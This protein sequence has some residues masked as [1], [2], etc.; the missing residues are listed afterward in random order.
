MSRSWTEAG[1]TRNAWTRP[2]VSVTDALTP[3]D[4]LVRVLPTR[5]RVRPGPDAPS[6]EDAGRGAPVAAAGETD[7]SVEHRERAV[8]HAR[9]AADGL[10]QRQ[11]AGSSAQAAPAR[12][13]HHNARSTVRIDHSRGRPI[14]AGGR[15]SMVAS[16]QT[17]AFARTTSS[18]AGA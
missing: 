15:A 14:R 4:L 10:S 13:S 7:A 3:V 2:S 6:I 9:A 16:R 11:P 8:E 5:P 18:I 1:T 12:H 17:V